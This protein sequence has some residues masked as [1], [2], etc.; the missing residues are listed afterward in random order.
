MKLVIVLLACVFGT[1][2]CSLTGYLVGS[3]IDRNSS[4]FDTLTTYSRL[5]PGEDVTIFKK[6]GTTATG[7]MAGLL[8]HLSFEQRVAKITGTSFTGFDSN[9]GSFS[10]AT[11]L[12]RS[13][14]TSLMLKDL[15]NDDV[16]IPM[17]SIRCIVAPHEKHA[18]F[19]GLLLGVVVDVA[20]VAII[21]GIPGPW[22]LRGP[23]R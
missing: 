23:G 10:N 9:T 7:T 17:D 13:V 18:A 19:T 4:E 12:K 21:A 14:P 5:S 16:Q 6:D 1:S 8:P 15:K 20:V 22:N 2:G 3:G 11:P